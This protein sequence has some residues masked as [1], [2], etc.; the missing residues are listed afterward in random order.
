VHGDFIGSIIIVMS[1]VQSYFGVGCVQ[2]PSID[3]F[4]DAAEKQP[5]TDPSV[6]VA[7]NSSSGPC[8]LCTGGMLSSS[9]ASKPGN[10]DPTMA[11]GHTTGFVFLC[12]CGTPTDAS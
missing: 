7:H 9:T 10:D 6:F 4:V 3:K 2:H 5:L 1:C 8:C 11:C 12:N